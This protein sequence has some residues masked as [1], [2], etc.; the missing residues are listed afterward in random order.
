M[1]SLIQSILRVSPT[2]SALAIGEPMRAATMPI[3]IVSQM[4]L[5]CRP[6]TTSRPLP[7]WLRGGEG[8]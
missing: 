3:A 1:M 4:D 5:S 8:I 2:P 6:G 7:R